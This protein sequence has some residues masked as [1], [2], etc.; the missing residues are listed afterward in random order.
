MRALA[1]VLAGLSIGASAAKP[2]RA[3]PPSVGSSGPPPAWVETARGSFWLAFSTF[4]WG[5]RCAD[6]RAPSCGER[7]VPK[8]RVRRGELV[9]FHLG[10]DPREVSVT[11]FGGSG[12]SK[13][14]AA[15]RN[16]VW[17]ARPGAFAVFALPKRR[18]GDA[19]YVACATVSG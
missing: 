16:P 12:A 9:R 5:G 4:C 10:F 2:P 1:L 19:S 14:L 17:R 7:Y 18:G 15:V 8:I 3:A 6:Y 11:T 13:R